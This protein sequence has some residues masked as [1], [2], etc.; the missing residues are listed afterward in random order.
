[1]VYDTRE[2]NRS[3]VLTELLRRRP[4]SR[5][6]IAAATGISAATVTRAVE[7]LMVEGI[8]RQ[9]RELPV[10]KRGRRAVLLDVVAERRHVVGVDL[11][12]TNTRIIVADLAG[13]PL[14]ATQLLTRQTADPAD[15]AGWLARTIEQLAGQDW[16]TTTEVCVGVPGAVSTADQAI[17]NA[18]NLPQ[19]EE[20]AFLETLTAAVGR[21]LRL[22]NDAN[23]A[24][25]GELHFGAAALADTAA[26]LTIGTGLG[27]GLAIERQVLRGQ[28]GLIGEFGQLPVGPLGARLEHMVTGLGIMRRAAE[29][30][31]SLAAPAELF[32]RTDSPQL[33]YLRAQFDQ[34]MLIVLAAVT[35]SCD[36]Q[37]IVIG[38]GVGRSLAPHIEGY[39]DSLRATLRVAPAIIPAALGDYSGAA[40]A[41]A[42][43]LQA[44]Y[45]DLGVQAEHLTDLPAV[46]T[47]T[48]ES[49]AAAVRS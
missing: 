27:T 1:V 17:S 29:A 24:L 18:P 20:P 32:E 39:R 22:D 30:G 26:M 14:A 43:G 19:V 5:R 23:C 4:V 45:L 25:L 10:G 9:E 12:A 42:E 48:A 6:D 37:C 13:R 38:G 36:P 16:A 49:I 3:A 8:V 47:L 41:V 35:V 21:T 15:L 46:G 40:G 11:G 7:G 31:V 44:S 34:A 33:A 28:H 2:L